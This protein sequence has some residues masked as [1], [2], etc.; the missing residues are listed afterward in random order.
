MNELLV[1]FII[2]NLDDSFVIEKNW[3]LLDIN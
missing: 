1:I 2:K 3:Q